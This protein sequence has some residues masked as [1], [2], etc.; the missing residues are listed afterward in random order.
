MQKRQLQMGE[1]V[2]RA[3]AEICLASAFH[4]PILAGVSPTISSVVMSA[5]LKNASVF[6]VAAG[7]E[8]EKQVVVALN[9]LVPFFKKNLAKKLD[10]RFIPHLRF[11]ADD[12]FQK[13]AHIETLL[14][15]L[16]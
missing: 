14:H 15:H 3:L 2:R 16:K 9:Q 8:Q 6:F 11:I 10:I 12:S 5:D 4:D 13:A 1:M 7:R